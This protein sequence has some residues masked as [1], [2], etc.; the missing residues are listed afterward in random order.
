M[1]NGIIFYYGRPFEIKSQMV[2]I[3]KG[4][5]RD[6]ICVMLGG[7]LFICF[8]LVIIPYESFVFKEFPE[9]VTPGFKGVDEDG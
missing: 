4:N 1:E 8:F 2:F 3:K 6:E 5:D 7:F 9:V